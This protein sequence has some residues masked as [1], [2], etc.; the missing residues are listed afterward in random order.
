MQW[1]RVEP[2]RRGRAVSFTSPSPA[3]VVRPLPYRAVHPVVHHDVGHIH[4]APAGA[5]VAADG[6]AV[7]TAAATS[8]VGSGRAVFSPGSHGQRA[9]VCTP[10][11]YTET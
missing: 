11:L 7:A 2:A 3:T 10:E 6:E 5:A 4:V 9:A 8:T 1:R